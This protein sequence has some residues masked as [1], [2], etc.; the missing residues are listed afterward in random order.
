MSEI[1]AINQKRVIPRTGILVPLPDGN[2]NLPPEGKDV[3]L[4]SYWYQRKFDGDVTFKDVDQPK[5]YGDV[6]IEDMVHATD[7]V[8]LSA[9]GL[10]KTKGK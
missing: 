4:D 10:S 2:G 5:F 6:T 9:L 3:I 8:P 1:Q 7:I